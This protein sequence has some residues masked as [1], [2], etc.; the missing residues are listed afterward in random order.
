MQVIRPLS[1][2][3]S[4][5]LFMAMGGALGCG[6]PTSPADAGLESVELGTG[7]LEFEQLVDDQELI[8]LSGL[9]GGYHFIVHARMAHLLPGD[10][11][12]PGQLGN[13]L[14]TFYIYKEDGTQIDIKAPPYRLGYTEESGEN[15]RL[16]SGRLLQID[17]DLV[18]Q[19]RLSEI[20]GE[21]LRL[22]VEIRD[23]EGKRAFDEVWIIAKEEIDE[24]P[25]A[26]M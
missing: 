14:T 13:P 17:Q 25:D 22:R 7:A 15:Y 1:L 11:D 4:L 10:P 3:L 19:D 23:V 26:G 24:L 20:Y 8:L 5:A 6:E 2:A 21:R 9:Q 16:P 12:R 18:E